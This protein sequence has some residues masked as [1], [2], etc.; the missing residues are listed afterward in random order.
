M[1]VVNYSTIRNNLKN[2][3]DIVTD[4]HETVI[5][6]RKNEKNVVLMSLDKYNQL[7]I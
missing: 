2:Y 7:I 5:V 3:C 6:T 1:L 4:S